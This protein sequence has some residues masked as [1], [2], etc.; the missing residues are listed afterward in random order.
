V[1]E[2]FWDSPFKTWGQLGTHV[3]SE[4]RSQISMRYNT[5]FISEKKV[6]IST[7]IE[8]DYPCQLTALFPSL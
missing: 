5:E 4:D 6:T 3:L 2:P 1:I 7:K 8:S